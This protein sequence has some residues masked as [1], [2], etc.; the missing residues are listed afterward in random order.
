MRR[1]GWCAVLLVLLLV[2]AGCGGGGGGGGGTTSSGPSGPVKEGGF[3]RIAAYDFVDSMNP[4]VGFNNDT[5]SV[6]QNIYPYLVQYD[7]ETLEFI[8]EFAQSWEAS[9]DGLTWTFHTV[10]DAKW[11]DGQPLTANDVA[12]TL[13][14]EI[15]YQDGSTASAAG[16]IANMVSAEATDDDTVVLHY[17]KPVPMVL[18]NLQQLAVLPEHVWAPL[19][20]GDGKAIKT[21]PNLPEDGKPLV[22]GGPFVLTDFKQDAAAVFERNPNYFGTKPHIDGFGLQLFSNDDAEITAL[23][24]GEID[25]IESVP[26]TAVQTLKDAGMTV[27]TG[28]ATLER[29]F[30]INSNPAKTT[31]RELLDPLVRQAFDYAIDRQGIVETAWLGFSSPATTFVPA[32]T[33]DWHDS[34]VQVWPFDLDKANELLDQAGYAVGADGIR[35]GQDGPMAYEVIFPRSE[36]GA[37]D[38][39]FQIIQD[40]FLKIGVKLTQKPMGDGAAF[41]E[42]IADDYSTFDLAM[43]NWTPPI[44]PD[45]VLSVLTCA[46][47]DSWSDSGYCNAKYDD[48]YAAQGTEM[49]D[50]KRHEIVD[51]MQRMI[52]DQRP[53]IMLTYDMTVDAWSPNWEG[54][55]ESVQGFFPGLSNQSLISV[56]QV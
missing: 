41:S 4:Y 37:G 17:S 44:D 25:A 43:W 52:Y 45:F 7:S 46:Q 34:S 49:N 38:R 20:T 56:H 29:D 18:A 53:Y 32:A 22:C 1:R 9:K 30:I 21:Y 47:W 39:A 55:V 35:V 15:E 19:A 42:I 26:V 31:H 51:E 40:D 16:G 13:T 27:F 11:S 2:V 50:R 12:F 28:P 6:F 10:P 14:M 54:F 33:G 5:Y 8:P 48:L 3:L 23:K 36:R 24:N